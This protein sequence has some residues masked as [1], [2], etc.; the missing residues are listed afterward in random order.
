MKNFSC[1]YQEESL[2]L[3]VLIQQ[4]Q[5][6]FNHSNYFEAM[7]YCNQQL[8]TLGLLCILQI[9]LGDLTCTR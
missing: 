6:T 4:L 1:I 9:Y 3:E 2:A 5:F 7:F 8:Y